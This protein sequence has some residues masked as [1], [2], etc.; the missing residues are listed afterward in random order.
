MAKRYYTTKSVKAKKV[1]GLTPK[2]KAVVKM[3]CKD[4]AHNH[5]KVY[6]LTIEMRGD[7]TDFVVKSMWG[8][9]TSPTF[10]EQVKAEVEYWEDALAIVQRLAQTKKSKGYRTVSAKIANDVI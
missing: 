4:S 7:G 5:D 6:F 9:R 1:L 3:W 8:R 10:M 2:R